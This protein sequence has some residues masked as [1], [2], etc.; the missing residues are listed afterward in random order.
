MDLFSCIF[1]VVLDVKNNSDGMPNFIIS[2]VRNFMPVTTF[3]SSTPFSLFS[4]IICSLMCC[5]MTIV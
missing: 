5:T 1:F 2:N 3:Y 4:I